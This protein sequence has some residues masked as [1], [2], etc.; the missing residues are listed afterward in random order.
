MQKNFRTISTAKIKGGS[1]Y[2]E[3]GDTLLS[4]PVAA[5]STARLT[6]SHNKDLVFN[7]SMG[8]K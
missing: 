4:F 5:G 1:E 2:T 3:K 8:A 6:V 7:M